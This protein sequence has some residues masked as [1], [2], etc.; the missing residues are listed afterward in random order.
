[1]CRILGYIFFFQILSF[2]PLNGPHVGARSPMWPLM[3][4]SDCFPRFGV[5]R[6]QASIYCPLGHG[7]LH[8]SIPCHLRLPPLAS[9]CPSS[10]PFPLRRCR[11][12]RVATGRPHC[13][14]DHHSAIPNGLRLPPP[15]SSSLSS[16]PP[17][18][19]T[20]HLSNIHET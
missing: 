14:H 2:N 9:S 16:P 5:R 15:A 10:P 4:P 6:P 20:C 17:P 12:L 7:S 13:H 1:M 3:T 8:S 11:P 19:T 18:C